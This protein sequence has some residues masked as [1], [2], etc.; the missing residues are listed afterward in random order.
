MS[1]PS[2]LT[3]RSTLLA[4]HR[5]LG[6]RADYG[7]ARGLAWQREARVLVSIG[8]AADD[9]RAVRLAPGAARAWK[10]MQTTA[11][12]DGIE[13]L[14]LSGFRSIARQIEIVRGKLAAG[15]SIDQILALV[16]APGYSEHHTGRALDVGSPANLKLETSF[17]RTR[18]FRWLKRRAHEFGFHLSY[19]RK[20]PH[21]IQYEPWH[22]CW[23]TPRPRIRGSFRPEL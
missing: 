20:N 19:P 13:I 7:A 1:G 6:I 4:I 17:A 21:G 16:A 15:Q 9:G 3:S 8:P 10:R 12:A 14:P 23:R 18:E 2:L 5:E 22:W 11:R